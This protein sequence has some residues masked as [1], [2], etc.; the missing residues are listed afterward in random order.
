MDDWN[1]YEADFQQQQTEQQRMLELSPSNSSPYSIN[2]PSFYQ[3]KP[4]KPNK[5]EFHQQHQPQPNSD[6]HDEDVEFIREAQ[7]T[8]QAK[9][10]PT[11]KQTT[12]EPAMVLQS[13]NP[14]FYPISGNRTTK[15][16]DNEDKSI[17]FASSNTNPR[18]RA[19][20]NDKLTYRNP[21]QSVH[22]PEPSKQN[23]NNN[24]NIINTLNT[25]LH[26]FLLKLTLMIVCDN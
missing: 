19:Q 24:T 26:I 16:V 15:A 5:G 22:R 8:P 12:T 21:Q 20:N 11:Y 1:D 14:S 4:Q 18:E 7:S 17:Y 2:S 10:K 25:C 13:S 23:N 9:P 3:E 6:Q